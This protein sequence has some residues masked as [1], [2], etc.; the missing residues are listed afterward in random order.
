MAITSYTGVLH[1]NSEKYYPV[2]L[3]SFREKTDQGEQR[4]ITILQA[5]EAAFYST[6]FPGVATIEEFIR[7]LKSLLF[8]SEAER[9]KDILKSLSHEGIK[10]Y[11]DNFLKKTTYFQQGGDLFLTVHIE[12]ESGAVDLSSL[13]NSNEWETTIRGN[14]IKIGLGDSASSMKRIMQKL[15]RNGNLKQSQIKE[16]FREG[17][18]K[19][20]SKNGFEYYN[21]A[22]LTRIMAE[23]FSLDPD[24]I[25]VSPSIAARFYYEG[26]AH[27]KN[28]LYGGTAADL[29]YADKNPDSF[30][31][32][33]LKEILKKLKA[34]I[35]S[36]FKIGSGSDVFQRAFETVW[37]QTMSMANGYEG[38]AFFEKGGTLNN[39]R[40]AF[41]EFQSSLL[42]TYVG[43]LLMSQGAS[44]ALESFVSDTLMQ[45]Q[46]KADIT[47]KNLFQ[48][49]GVQ[50]KNYNPAE[51]NR[52]FDINA[53]PSDIVQYKS[54][55]EI[56]GDSDNFLTFVANYYFNATYRSAHASDYS[57]VIWALPILFA[58]IANLETQ[59][60]LDDRITFYYIGGSHFVPAS[61]ILSAYYNHV[62]SVG[63]F[64]MTGPSTYKDDNYFRLNK[65][66][67]DDTLPAGADY[68][69]FLGDNYFV[70]NDKNE[71]KFN[72]LISSQI[73]L[74]GSFNYST[75][76]NLASYSLF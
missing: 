53:H 64:S 7:R 54:F 6:L 3:N 40:G 32:E 37:N 24:M 56:G 27:I 26:K 25:T 43:L 50:V 33:E 41:G 45:Q 61:V 36:H 21:W 30:E 74:R 72:Q 52:H 48:S 67:Y 11:I 73:S 22:G 38:A 20:T 1:T 4:E 75:I 39:V 59:Q 57:K 13:F 5:K 65:S 71:A 51:Q 63:N 8:S 29:R 62:L 14:E 19:K 10:S 12:S 46:N 44:N 49:W 35:F 69:E 15:F 42:F 55:S 66:S 28:P 9:D 23:N 70:K 60:E 31:A 17:K 58:E 47:L 68:F 2:G 18:K 34:Q 16:L 76:P